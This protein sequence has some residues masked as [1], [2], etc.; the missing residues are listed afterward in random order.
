MKPAPETFRVPRGSAFREDLGSSETPHSAIRLERA[1]SKYKGYGLSVAVLS[2][3][4]SNLGAE[5]Q[6]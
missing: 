6:E 2:D 4:A 3:G 1:M 5:P